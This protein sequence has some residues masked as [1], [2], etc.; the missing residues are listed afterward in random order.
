MYWAVDGNQCPQS[1]IAASK[2]VFR[3]ARQVQ[4]VTWFFPP[5]PLTFCHMASCI[6]SNANFMAMLN[7]SLQQHCVQSS[8]RAGNKQTN[9]HLFYTICNVCD[10]TDMAFGMTRGV[11]HNKAERAM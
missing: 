9:T 8:R 3:H 5:R 6:C 2:I 11:K 4:L 10:S 7:D 1:S